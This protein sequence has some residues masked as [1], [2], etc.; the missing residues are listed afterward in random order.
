MNL[1]CSIEG[2]SYLAERNGI[3]SRHNREARKAST[4]KAKP[5]RKRIAKQSEEGRERMAVY[6]AIRE[7]FLR[8]N[9]DCARC[10]EVYGVYMLATT[11]H[12]KS[13]RLSD[14]LYDVRHFLP[15]CIVCHEYV[16]THPEESYQRGWSELRNANEPHEI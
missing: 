6:L 2:C 16:E 9:P 15:L 14:S 13:G 1:L 8:Y 12:H 7:L 11:V 5:A 4:P 3:C 10:K